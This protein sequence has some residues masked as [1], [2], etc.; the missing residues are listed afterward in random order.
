VPAKTAQERAIQAA[1]KKNQA[2]WNRAQADPRPLRTVAKKIEDLGLY[3]PTTNTLVINPRVLKGKVTG[4]Y[5]VT[6]V[7]AATHETLHFVNEPKVAAT[8]PVHALEAADQITALLEGTQPY[9]FLLD[10]VQ[11]AKQNRPA[12]LASRLGASL[13]A[14][15]KDLLEGAAP[16]RALTEALSYL[17]EE[18]LRTSDP[19]IKQ[20]A[21]AFQR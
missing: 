21:E 9:P 15:E 18:S 8:S 3:D 20:L 16:R 12:S 6:P 17:G 14:R 1:M 10:Y 2:I 11:Q 5:K 13:S 7:E 19:L 4:G